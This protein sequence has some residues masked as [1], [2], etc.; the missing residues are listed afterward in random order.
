MFAQHGIAEPRTFRA[1]GRS[2]TLDTLFALHD[3][4]YL[5]DSSAL[6]W[7]YLQPAWKGKVLASWNMVHWAPIEDTSRPYWPSQRE[8]V[9][10]EPGASLGAVA[11]PDNG[12]I[13][14][15]VSLAEIE[16]IFDENW[17]G[18]ALAARTR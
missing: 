2:A 9:R 15:Y 6:N 1:G 14:D 7:K 11:V 4:G 10:V 13:I 16:M 12:V 17:A 5:A 8:I 3:N 18:N